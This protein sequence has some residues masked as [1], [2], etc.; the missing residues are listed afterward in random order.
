M[1]LDAEEIDPKLVRKFQSLCG[2][3]L[4]CAVNTRPDVAYAVG[5]LCRS[6]ARPTPELYDDALRVL[7]YLHFTADLGFRYQA[8]ERDLSGMSDSDWAA[9]YS[10]TGWLFTYSQ[11]AI[12]WGSKKQVSVALSSCE[13]EIV[14]LSEASKEVAYL[15]RFFEELGLGSDGPTSL[16]TDNSAAQNLSYNPE[17]H[18]RTKHIERRHFFVRDLVEDGQLVVPLV[19]TVDNLADFFTKALPPAMFY[20]MQNAIMNVDTARE[21]KSA[22]ADGGVLE[23]G[24]DSTVTVNPH[25]DHVDHVEV[26]VSGG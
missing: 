5:M 1:L 17:H 25:V 23:S 12:T 4:Y 14:A 2:A 6:M 24:S 9:R 11:A 26:E 15:R 8:D 19:S 18:E 3:L 10:T 20:R 16:A 21:A 22:F 7:Y 13:A